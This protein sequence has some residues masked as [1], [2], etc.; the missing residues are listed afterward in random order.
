MEQVPMVA[1]AAGRGIIGDRYESGTGAYKKKPEVRNLS[2]ISEEALERANQQGWHDSFTAS[3]TATWWFR[4]IL[5]RSM[6]R[7]TRNSPSAR[8]GY[9]AW[10]CAR[11]AADL[12]FSA[13]SPAS[14]LP[15]TASAVC[16]SVFSRMV[17]SLKA[18]TFDLLRKRQL[19]SYRQ[20][21]KWPLRSTRRSFLFQAHS[22][23]GG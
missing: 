16:V 6:R 5:K 23:W 14:P 20:I 9:A 4:W 8:S 18:M 3:D 15:L 19:Y 7:S 12:P 21:S 17:S 2:L 1:V 11:L 22:R 10:N 13:A